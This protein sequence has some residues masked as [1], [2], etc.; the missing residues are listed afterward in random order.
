MP[1]SVDTQGLRRLL[2]AGAA[3]VE[4]LPAAAYVEEHIPGA[5]N[6]PLADIA[7]A[8]ERLDPRR[9]VAVYCFDYQ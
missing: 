4:V 3:L 6:L 5:V 8:P 7:E 1:T 9:P 2:E